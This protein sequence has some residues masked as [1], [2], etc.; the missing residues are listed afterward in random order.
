MTVQSDAIT[1]EE[2]DSE[3]ASLLEVEKF[4]PPAAFREEALLKDPEVYERAAADPLGWWTAQAEELDWFQRW[5][6]VLDDDDPPFYKWFTGGMLNVS[7]NCLDRHVI[8]GRGERVAFHWRGEAGEERDLTY[9]E[10]LEQVER[11]ASAL[12]ELGVRKGDVVG[13][14]LPMIPEGVGALLAWARI[15]APHNGVFGGFSAEAVR[16]R[17]EFSEAKVLITVD[18]AARKG[19]TAPVK[20]RVDEVMGDLPSL[21]KIVVV[22]SKGTPCEMRE[23]RDVFYDEICAAADPVCPAEPLDSEHPL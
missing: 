17:M 23:G 15:G 7:Y 10:L 5:S 3:L 1:G 2:L 12:K 18:G 4:E 22:K 11:F 19:K 14:Y 16:E 13:I 20:E 6:R 21:E 8:A 9:A